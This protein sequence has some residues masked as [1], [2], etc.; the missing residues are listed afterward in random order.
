MKYICNFECWI[1]R[2]QHWRNTRSPNYVQMP[3]VQTVVAM[4]YA[5]H[6]GVQEEGDGEQN[7]PLTSWVARWPSTM[8]SIDLIFHPTSVTVAVP[9]LS[10]GGLINV[11]GYKATLLVHT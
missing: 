8:L 6:N 7:V 9:T 5:P 1:L 10:F 11:I 2:M 4:C 3:Y